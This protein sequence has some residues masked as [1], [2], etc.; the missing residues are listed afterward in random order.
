MVLNNGNSIREKS[1]RGPGSKTMYI[2]NVQTSKKAEN[3]LF[4]KTKICFMASS[5]QEILEFLRSNC[6]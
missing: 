1:I 2:F 5:S 4:S 3:Y 6:T